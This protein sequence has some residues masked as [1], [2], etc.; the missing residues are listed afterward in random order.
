[1]A[2]RVLASAPK[3]FALAGHSI[4]GRVALEVMRLILQTPQRVPHLALLDMGRH[5][6]T[7]GEA[8]DQER[9]ARQAFLTQAQTQGV[10][11][12]ARHWVQGMVH[13]ARL[14]DAALIESIV[15]MFERK[16]AELFA[17]QI[18]ALLARPEAYPVLATIQC[19]TLGVTR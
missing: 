7:S 10:A 19:P 1:M 11:A 3:Y 4:G 9:A 18:R 12:M 16:S 2:E 8:G 13:A 15:T 5:A 14:N 6:L 17:A